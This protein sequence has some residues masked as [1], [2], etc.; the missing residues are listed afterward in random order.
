MESMGFNAE[1]SLGNQHN[2]SIVRLNEQIRLN[3]QSIL[4][5]HQNDVTQAQNAVSNLN[6]T[7]TETKT[8]AE[9]VGGQVASKGKDIQAAGKVVQSTPQIATALLNTG[10]DLLFGK[11]Q[12]AI[13]GVRNETNLF[14]DT[15]AFLSE[16]VSKGISIGDK[17]SSIGKLGIASTGL[18]VGMGLLDGIQ[19]IEAHKIEGNN[20][21][22]RV[23]NVAGILS[24]GLEAAG[25]ALDL[26][27]IG[28]P[29]GV[30]LNLAGGLAGLVSGVS[31]AV[32]EVQENQ[33]ATKTAT[34]VAKV[35]PTQEKTIGVI[36]TAGSGA[37]VRK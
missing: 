28:A 3:N 33:A 21:A 27:G 31:D 35:V 1:L 37:E 5:K 22:E 36:D 6:T 32:G 4:S 2:D 11:E 26:T 25:T 30:A 15:S 20:T 24:G 17:V 14:K 18:S 9:T 8:I 12:F 23:A 34:D 16:N 19:D 29:L 7:D 10:E 13:Q